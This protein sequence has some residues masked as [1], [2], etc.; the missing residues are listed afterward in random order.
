MRMPF[1]ETGARFAF[2][3]LCLLAV[4]WASGS[5]HDFGAGQVMALAD[6]S[7]ATLRTVGMAVLYALPFALMFGVPA[8]LRPG[9][10]LD[11]LLQVPVMLLAAVPL[12]ITAQMLVRWYPE[13]A[14]REIVS[15]IAAGP[16]LA[17]G[18]RDG[19][20]MAAGQMKAMMLTICCSGTILQEFGNLIVATFPL[21]AVFGLGLVLPSGE[22]GVGGF[23]IAG[24]GL[25][26]LLAHFA[27]DLLVSVAPRQQGRLGPFGPSRTWF[28]VGAL[29]LIVPVGTALLGCGG[30]PEGMQYGLLIALAASAVAGLAGLLLADLGRRLGAVAT[31]LLTPRVQVP[32][33]FS[34]LLAGLVFASAHRTPGGIIV[35]LGL[36]S[37][38]AMGYALRR[39]L[40]ERSGPAGRGVVG[41]LAL[42]MAQSLLGFALA[43]WLARARETVLPSSRIL[44][45]TAPDQ[46]WPATVTLA[47]AGGL[48]LIG[49]ALRESAGE[50]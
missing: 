5:L 27:G 30:Q 37:A 7:A 49:R 12:L 16:W 28:A 33:L 18:I 1:L 9:S 21:Q 41:A 45:V 15:A 38:P 43:A 25:T 39:W 6:S 11:R 13:P 46:L 4:L 8:G 42:V 26:A 10:L 24:L 34:G 36:V 40:A 22:S 3:T 23:R 2:G 19:L 14:S 50:K 17:I 29:L 31:A 48:F 44:E 35:V 32:M 47:L 20:V